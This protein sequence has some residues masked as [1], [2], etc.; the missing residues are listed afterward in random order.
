LTSSVAVFETAELGEQSERALPAD[1][2][3]A[4]TAI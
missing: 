2:V 3:A 4:T 1:G